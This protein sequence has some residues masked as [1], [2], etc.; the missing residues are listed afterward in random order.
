VL[1]WSKDHANQ[2]AS[3]SKSLS[4]N[5]TPN[6]ILNELEQNWKI[7]I[8][9]EYFIN[10]WCGGTPPG[11]CTYPDNW[12]FQQSYDIGKPDA[13]GAQYNT[14]TLFEQDQ[15]MFTLSPNPWIPPGSGPKPSDNGAPET[16]ITGQTDIT[17][18]RKTS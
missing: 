8:P 11:T 12:V 3:K 14:R 7:S 15:L 4:T 13:G 9:R 16:S 1:T 5:P 6:E 18:I 2:L 10:G 17:Y